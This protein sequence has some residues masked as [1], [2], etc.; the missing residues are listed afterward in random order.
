MTCAVLCARVTY[1]QCLRLFTIIDIDERLR[2]VHALVVEQMKVRRAQRTLNVRTAD[3][4]GAGDDK[5]SSLNIEIHPQHEQN[6]DQLSSII[7]RLLN[8]GRVNGS[9]AKHDG[10]VVDENAKLLHQLKYGC[11]RV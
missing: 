10:E 4:Q 2:A 7:G 3:A 8:G 5:S 11:W 1:E 6:S 9:T